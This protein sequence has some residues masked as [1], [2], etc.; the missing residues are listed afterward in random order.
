MAII[1]GAWPDK[2][3]DHI[4]GDPADNRAENLRLASAAENARN[5]GSKGGTSQFCGVHLDKSN[6]KWAAMCRDDDGK[7]RWLGHFTCE[8]E[9]ARAYDMAASR[10]HGPFAR[11]NFPEAAA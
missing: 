5:I 7:R 4:N 1:N 11:L 8:A 2:Q 9:A 3:V 6:N 10:W